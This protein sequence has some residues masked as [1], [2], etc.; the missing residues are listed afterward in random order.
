M[1]CN[2]ALPLLHEYLDGSL[3][4][5]D[6][7]A[8][9][10][11]LLGCAECRKRLQQFEKMEALISA[12]TPSEVPEGLTE[13]IMQ[14]LPPVKRHNPFYRWVRKHPAVSVAAVF[15]LVM[16]SSFVS[17]WNDDQELLVKGSDLESVV[18]KGNT[19]YVPAGATVSGDLTVENGITQ[20]DGDIKGSL[21]VIDGSVNL[22]STAHISGQVKTIDEAFSWLW[23]KMNAWIVQLSDRK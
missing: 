17:V 12:K 21:I 9:K 4:G 5:R 15:F 11:H 3:Q 14:A 16:F 22:A 23:Y 20:V 1:D 6:S 7:A 13:R 10:Q 8:L 2:E 19:V 18:I